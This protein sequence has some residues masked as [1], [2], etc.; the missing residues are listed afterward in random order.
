MLEFDA[1]SP[2]KGIN[3]IVKSVLISA[4]R[5]LVLGRFQ[6]AGIQYTLVD[7]I[8]TGECRIVAASG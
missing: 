5:I 2:E 3:R 6:I 1:R 8:A 4:H 7:P